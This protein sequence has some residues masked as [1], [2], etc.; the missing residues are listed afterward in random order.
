MPVVEPRS[1]RRSALLAAA[2]AATHAP[3]ALLYSELL[4]CLGLREV[5]TVANAWASTSSSIL[6]RWCRAITTA[7]SATVGASHRARSGTST[8]NL[9]RM[10]TMMRAACNEWPP[11]SRS[12]W[13]IPTCSWPTTSAQILASAASSGLEAASCSAPGAVV[14]RLAPARPGGR[15][16]QSASVGGGP[17]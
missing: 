1:S 7:R 13:L 5:S 4:P 12:V 10:P 3:L 17:A 16:C 6:S 8:P 14:R 2:A 9:A 15:L 11:R